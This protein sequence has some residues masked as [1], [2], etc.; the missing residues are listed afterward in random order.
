[1]LKERSMKVKHKDLGIEKVENK[2]F[3]KQKGKHIKVSMMAKL[4]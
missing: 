2:Y 3:G 1:M 4:I